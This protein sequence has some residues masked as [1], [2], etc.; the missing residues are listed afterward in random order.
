VLS[1]GWTQ[2]AV[3]FMSTRKSAIPWIFREELL[4]LSVSEIAPLLNMEKWKQLWQD[5]K[6]RGSKCLETTNR[7]KQGRFFPVEVN[8]TY[9]QFDGEEFVF[10]FV[11][12][13]TERKKAEDRLRKLSRAVEQSPA[14]VVITDTQGTIEYVNSK[15]TQVTGYTAEEA[16]GRNPRILNSGIQSAAVYRELWGTVLGGGEWRGEL[17]T[18][19]RM[20]RSIGN[21]PALCPSVTPAEPSPIFSRSRKTSPS[22]KRQKRNCD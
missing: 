7:S 5:L 11:R 10:A 16:I 14:I 12:D 13:I 20:E 4:S 9:L 15:F 8:A 21:P 3:S 18:R 2:T 22:A 6:V 19:R 1:V 17:A